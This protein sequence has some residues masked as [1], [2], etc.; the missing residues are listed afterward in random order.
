MSPEQAKGRAVDT[1][2][3][4]WAFGAVL[5]E[6]LTGRRAFGGNDVSEIL[7]HVLMQEPDWN[8]LPARTPA[9][10]RRLLRRCLEKDRKRRLDSAAAARFDVEEAMTAAAENGNGVADP[11]AAWR[12]ALPWAVVGTLAVSFVLVLLGWELGRTAAPQAPVRVHVALGADAALATVDRG[13]A[14]IL[15]PNGQVF[16]FVAQR[17]SGAP[18]LYVRR[19]DQLEAT[20]LAGT[21]NAHSPFFSPDGEWIAFFAD[22]KL[23]KVALSGG[24]PVML[25]DTPD[26]KGG[27]WAADGWIVYAPFFPGTDRGGLLRVSSTGG[28][29]TPLTSLADG[30]VAHGW[31]QMLP[32]GTALLYTGHTSRTNWDD[33][34]LVVQ[35]LPTGSRKIIQQGGSYGRY[36]SSGHIAYLH[37][38][39][40]FAVPFDLERLEVRGPPVLALDGVASNPNGGSAQFAASETG[41]VVLTAPLRRRS[42]SS[43]LRKSSRIPSQSQRRRF[44]SFRRS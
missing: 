8:A 7:A 3:D 37:A 27:S 41:T 33:A 16:A 42:R 9:P 20:P 35:P 1:R 18:S 2:A 40:V 5:Y 13:S 32:G 25:C 39:K 29:P 24:A 31:P 21:D 26:G 11:P 34:T 15:S 14:A 38:G 44:F 23:K 4:L 17:R 6:M 12:R 30:E 10:I 43:R 36:L 28:V 19:L 22:A